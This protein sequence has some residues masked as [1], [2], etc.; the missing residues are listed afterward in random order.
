[1][2]GKYHLAALPT[3]RAGLTGPWLSQIWLLLLFHFLSLLRQEMQGTRRSAWQWQ[4]PRR[5]IEKKAAKSFFFAA[6]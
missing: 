4:V 3:A 5:A 6:E 1:M 2:L